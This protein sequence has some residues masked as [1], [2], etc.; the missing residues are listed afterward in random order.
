MLGP[1]CISKALATGTL[2]GIAD[3]PDDLDILV[4]SLDVVQTAYANPAE[5]PPA[6]YRLVPVLPDTGVGD[7]SAEQL[8]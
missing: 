6:R 7:G 3:G 4:T 2:G 8:R 5:R 1:I